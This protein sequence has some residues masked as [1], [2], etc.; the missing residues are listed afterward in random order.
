M[1]NKDKE[2]IRQIITYGKKLQKMTQTIGSFENFKND[3]ILFDSIISIS[4]VI[5]ELS[6][7]LSTQTKNQLSSI[8]WEKISDYY[9]QIASDFHELDLEKLW[10]ALTT[11]LNSLLDKLEQYNLK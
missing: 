7:K 9:Q 2:I 6:N 8:N 4:S 11:D 5:Y 10:T 1:N 3:K